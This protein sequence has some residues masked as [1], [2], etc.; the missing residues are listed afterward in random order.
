VSDAKKNLREEVKARL[1][2]LSESERI[3]RGRRA[4]ARLLQSAEYAAA[5]TILAYYSVDHEVDTHPLLQKCFEDGK[6]IGLPR[7]KKGDCSM[8]FH[9][10]NNLTADLEPA[11]FKFREPK[12]MLPLITAEQP[13]LIVV[14]GLAFDAAC[15]RLGR[16]AGYYDRFL[17]GATNAVVCALAFE[18]QILNNIPSQ[19]HDEPVHLIFTED[20]TLTCPAR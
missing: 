3:E 19:S 1:K 17:P 11:H 16:G 2:V 9:A 6:T 12:A 18:C 15:N 14:P 20:R 13:D 7:T 8:R 5:R 4:L 10:I